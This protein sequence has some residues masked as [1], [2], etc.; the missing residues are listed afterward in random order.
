MRLFSFWVALTLAS[1]TM[2]AECVQVT[3]KD[4]N[5]LPIMTDQSLVG[6]V[7][8]NAPP[9][10]DI[11]LPPATQVIAGVSAAC[12][13]ALLKSVRELFDASCLTDEQRAATVRANNATPE[14]VNKRCREIYVGLNPKK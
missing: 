4:L 3:L 1:P 5:G 9:L 14:N 13:A 7:L 6:F 12:P 2:A 8:P 10:V 11:E